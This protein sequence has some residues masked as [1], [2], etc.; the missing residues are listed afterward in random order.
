MPCLYSVLRDFTGFATAAL[1]AWTPMVKNAIKIANDPAR[2]NTHHAIEMRYAKSCSHL[3][4]KYHAN[5]AAMNNATIT[6][7]KKSLVNNC[8]MAGSEAP[9]TLRIPIS[10]VRLTTANAA[11]PNNPRHARNTETPPAH[12]MMLLH[13]L[14]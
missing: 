1:T 6:N 5:G 8:T 13:L 10:L 9:N 3:F 11:S 7:L 4:M 12:P 2:I 14:S